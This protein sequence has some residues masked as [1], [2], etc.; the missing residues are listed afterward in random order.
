MDFVQFAN[1]L[2]KSRQENFKKESEAAVKSTEKAEQPRLPLSTTLCGECQNRRLRLSEGDNGRIIAEFCSCAEDVAG[3]EERE[4]IQEAADALL[5]AEI[6][7][8]YLS[9]LDSKGVHP[10]IL[11]WVEKH[12]SKKEVPNTVFLYGGVGAGKTHS[13]I[14]ALISVFPETTSCLYLPTYKFIELR[15]EYLDQ[16]FSEDKEE[17]ARATKLF[18]NYHRFLKKCDFLVLDE[19][20]QEKLAPDESKVL[21]QILDARYSAGK[22]TICISNHSDDRKRSLDG[23]ELTSLVGARIA[24]RLKSAQQIYFTGPDLRVQEGGE[25]I[26]REEVESFKV[27]AKILTHDSDT[28]HIMNW[29]TRNPAFETVSPQR[30]NELTEIINE[31]VVDKDRPHA[32]VY[33]DVW[34]AGDQL[35]VQGP[36]C[37]HED[38]KL[39]ALLVKELARSHQNGHSGLILNLSLRELLRLTDIAETGPNHEKMK[40][41]LIRLT[42]MS[43]DF[44]ND[45]GNRWVGP[46]LNDVVFPHARSI[47]K[48][49]IEFNRF[50]ITFYRLHA[51]TTFS[52]DKS[53]ILKG[54][55][56]AFYLFYS[57]HSNREMT[58]TLERCKKLLAI[59][60]SFDKKE[61]RKRIKRA[62]E[63]LIEAKVMDPDGTF[64]KNGKV[65][66]SLAS[67]LC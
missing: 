36:V 30:R 31:N 64:I 44:K 56:S 5:R 17:K 2:V 4:A 28:H 21:F 58:I 13:A 50:M 18:R 45:K 55:S 46:L 16:R 39:Y 25:L 40:R 41:Q 59:G 43:L 26:S 33:S 23:K 1:D 7:N 19:L 47:E 34:V 27:P 38:K 8:R 9:A 14:H 65:Y 37:D 51:F 63:N 48:T 67:E 3:W 6:P 22:V 60:D 62:V 11:N 32:V 12:K 57:S 29:L 66:T 52:A 10:E 24:S 35:I 20:G 54:D 15:N 53:K 61:A 49:R 42:R